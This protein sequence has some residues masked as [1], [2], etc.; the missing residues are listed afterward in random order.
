MTPLEILNNK[1]ANQFR[2]L[3]TSNQQE[4]HFCLAMEYYASK[5]AKDYAQWLAHEVIA[6]RTASKLWNDY[7]NSKQ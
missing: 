6:G 4:Y 7:Q 1:S 3:V 2:E 5:V